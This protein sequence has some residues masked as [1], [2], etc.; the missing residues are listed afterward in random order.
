M[1]EI[2]HRFVQAGEIR[3]HVAEAGSGPLVIL[4]HG[5][6]E[7]WYSW[8][9]QLVAL[10]AAG[11]RAVAPDQRGYGRT[12]RPDGVDAYTI[13][14][15]VGDVVQ[16]VDALGAD[17]AVVAGHDWGGVVAWHAAL[18][19]PDIVRGVVSLSTPFQPH[20][21][22][23]HLAGLRAEAGDDYENYYSVYFQRPGIADKELGQDPRA[24]LR[25]LLHGASA[26][27]YPWSPIIPEGGQ[28]LDIWP[29]PSALPDWLTEE[30]IDTVAADYARTGF[31]PALNWFRNFDRNWVLT[32]PWHKAVVRQP[33][34]YITGDRDL[35]GTLPGAEELIEGRSANVPHAQA[36]V[37]LDCGHWIQQE[38]PED[39]NEALTAFL[40]L[41]G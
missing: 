34:L 29:E 9:H 26:E 15:T 39:V 8:R 35:A 22:G 40:E 16:L 11:Y 37:L 20:S 19:R 2:A 21:D 17:Q 18:M 5:F 3:M 28:V 1:T 7:T 4:L 10:A 13:L 27:G 33:A 30:D 12:D 24:T 38:R 6:P 14:H 31:T 23:P 32:S 41:L 36:A 25:R